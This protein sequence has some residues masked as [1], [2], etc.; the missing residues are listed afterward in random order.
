MTS[1]R[2]A[3]VKRTDSRSF[4]Y[5]RT[6]CEGAS[7]V[8]ALLANPSAIAS[9]L[10]AALPLRVM[11]G[12]LTAVL[13]AP[14][15]STA[16]SEG[17]SGGPRWAPTRCAELRCRTEIPTRIQEA[18]VLGRLAGRRIGRPLADTDVERGLEAIEAVEDPDA[19]RS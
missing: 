14:A 18:V 16:L 1:S 12:D 5:M 19:S 9:K 3:A 6:F 4:R 13:S 7:A 8:H 15:T 17:G 2:G 11:R 10:T